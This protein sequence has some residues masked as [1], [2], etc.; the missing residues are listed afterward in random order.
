MPIE[1]HPVPGSVVL[2]DFRKGFREPEMVKR[3]PAVVLSPNIRARG[4]LCTVV[5]LST[6]KPNFPQSFHCEIELENP[7]PDPWNAEKHWVKGD[8]IYAIG[9]H[10]I[11]LFR[12]G[13]DENGKRIYSQKP[14]SNEHIKQIKR[15]VL[16]G[17]GMQLLTKH[18]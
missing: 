11:E 10:R 8:M 9:F 15:C 14:L 18:L 5:A 1:Y 12:D 7:L 4:K 6:T 13:R 16:N 17:L 2:C 3:R